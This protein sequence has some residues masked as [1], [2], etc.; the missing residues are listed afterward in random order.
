MKNVKSL[1]F[2]LAIAMATALVSVNSSTLAQQGNPGAIWTTRVDCGDE[3]Q[4][5]NQY[6]QGEFVFINGSNFDAGDYN[7]TITGQPGNASGD[8]NI[9]VAS[10]SET[11]DAS[12]AFCFSAYQIALDDCGEYTVDF[13]GNKNDNY[14]ISVRCQAIEPTPSPTPNPEVT[15]TPTP[16]S[17]GDICANIDGVQTTVPADH[18][19][20]ASGLNCVQFQLGGPPAPSDSG[21]GGQV[22]GASTLGAT[23]GEDF[24]AMIFAIGSFTSGLGVRKYGYANRANHVESKKASKNK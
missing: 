8:P 19:L 11:I 20:D 24:L 22:L 18:H 10:G 12:G 14:H 17:N 5:A 2:V 4:D 15:P 9:V 7:W 3:Q 16:V 6:D 23:G 13:G 21:T 1:I